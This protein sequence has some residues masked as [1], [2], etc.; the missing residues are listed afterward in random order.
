M[1]E[2]NGAKILILRKIFMHLFKNILVLQTIKICK[3]R[4]N[5]LKEKLMKENLPR[6]RKSNR[7]KVLIYKWWTPQIFFRVI[8]KMMYLKVLILIKISK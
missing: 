2:L 3:I 8:L 6:L 7:L 4:L 1:Y 5:C